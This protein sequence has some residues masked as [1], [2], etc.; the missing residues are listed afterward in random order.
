M[1]KANSTLDSDELF[2]LALNATESDNNEDA[3][4]YLKRAHQLSPDNANII[5]MLGAVHAQIGMFD[6]AVE[7]M[8]KAVSLDP[9]I[10][11]AHFQ[12]GM[13]YITSGRPREAEK[14]W[15]P[16]NDLGQAHPFF[17]FKTGL[18][19]LA[20]DEFAQCVDYIKR[21]IAANHINEPLNRDMEKVLASAEQAL[22]QRGN[23][24][25]ALE[26]AVSAARKPVGKRLLSA[27]ENDNETQGKH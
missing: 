23:V 11:A 15:L 10:I 27:Y 21:G 7:E 13:L 5:Y 19:H 24:K 6:R 3:I 2:H 18:L 17:L 8:S 4:E 9:S 12:L 20:N 14:A 25:D 22:A 1:N 16:L 26:K